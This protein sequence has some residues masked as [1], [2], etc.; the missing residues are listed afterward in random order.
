VGDL[1][2]DLVVKNYVTV[3]K[4]TSSGNPPKK[5]KSASVTNDFSSDFSRDPV[6]TI[7][8]YSNKNTGKYSKIV[9]LGKANFLV[10][11]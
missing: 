7:L 8:Y 2:G 5:R 4:S 1:I 3:V 6:A 9:S 11:P 10:A